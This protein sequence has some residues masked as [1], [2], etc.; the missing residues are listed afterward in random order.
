MV[1]S[2]FIGKKEK[3]AARGFRINSINRKKEPFS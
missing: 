3:K 1:H 2:S